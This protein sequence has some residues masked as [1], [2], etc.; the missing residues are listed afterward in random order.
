[1]AI[2]NGVN[3]NQNLN[4]GKTKS[5]DFEDRMKNYVSTEGITTKQ[6]EIGLWYVEHKRQLRM[7]LNGFLILI[8]AVSWVYTIYG[9]AYYIARGMNEDEILT[10]QLVQVNSVGHDYIMQVGAKDLALGPVEIIRSAD[11]KYELFVKL[12]ND[13][14]KLWAEFDYYFTAAGRQTEKIKGYILPED[15]KYLAA[16]A[17]DF[18]YSP[19]GAELIMENISWRRV[20][21]HQITDWEAYR[22]GHLNIASADIKFIPANASPLSEKLGLNQLSFNVINHTAYNYWSVGFAILLYNRDQITAINHYVLNDFMSE[23]KRLVEISWPGDLGRADRIEII[24]E[25][26][27]MKDDIYIKYDGGI[28]QEK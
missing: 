20:N 13:N 2:S 7:V 22:A 8:S 16:L 6:L 9:F 28:G 12:K 19:E 14:P 26:N 3:N 1:M 25:I 18:S 15:I 5:K 23:Q 24:P 27:I 10:R 11:K 21:Q 17:E 4:Q